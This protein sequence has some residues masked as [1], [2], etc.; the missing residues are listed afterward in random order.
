MKTQATLAALLVVGAASLPAAVIVDFKMTA[1]GA[2]LT[3]PVSAASTSS[4]ANIVATSLANQVGAGPAGS[5]NY[6]AGT[7]R[8][9]FWSTTA[10]TSTV[11]YAGA[12]STGNYVTFSVTAAAGY[13]VTFD[14]ITFQAG[15]ATQTATTKRSFYLVSET[16]AANFTAASTVLIGDSTPQAGAG[17]LTLPVQAGT[18]TNSVPNDYSVS[19]ASFAKLNAGETRIFR[20]YLQTETASQSIAFDD[21]VLNG[22]VT[23]SAVPEPSSFA[24]LAGVAMLG[25]AVV[26]RR[27]KR[28]SGE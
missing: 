24:A 9:S 21:I 27:A 19:L 14:S 23:A 20:F 10:G 18:I 12:F 26:R 22:T 17:G 25:C 7:D 5:N 2:P 8:V 3:D 1:A 4:D 16:S 6:N 15:A 11:S 13:E 28:R